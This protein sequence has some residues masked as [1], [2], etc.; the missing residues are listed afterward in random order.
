MNV[1]A[2]RGED[3]GQNLVES[4]HVFLRPVVFD[5]ELGTLHVLSYVLV[6]ILLPQNPQ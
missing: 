2:L 3:F 6:Q 1:G 5:D 4:L